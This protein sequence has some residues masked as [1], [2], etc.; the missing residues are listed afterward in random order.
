M[1]PPPKSATDFN[2]LDL[3]NQHPML[4]SMVAV[5]EDASEWNVFETGS[6]SHI[7]EDYYFPASSESFQF[8][9]S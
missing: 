6:A 8:T 1:H 3:I 9:G 2:L 5:I 4:D 7:T